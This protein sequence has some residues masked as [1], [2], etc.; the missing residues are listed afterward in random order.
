[1]LELADA[2][3]VTGHPG[4][5]WEAMVVRTCREHGGFEPDIRHRVNDATLALALVAQGLAVTLLPSLALRRG[6][7]R[8]RPR[9]SA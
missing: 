1:M 8:G 3:W 4:M 5:A 6:S 7:L 2:V 9:S